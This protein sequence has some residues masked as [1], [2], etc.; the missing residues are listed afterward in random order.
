MVFSNTVD[1]TK[2]REETMFQSNFKRLLFQLCAFTGV[3][4]SAPTTSFGGVVTYAIADTDLGSGWRTSSGPKNDI[5]GNNILGSDGWFVSGAAGSTQ[6]P[7]YL[8]SLITNGSVYPGNG[9]YARIDDPNTTP[10]LTPSTLQS[11]TL[12]PFPGFNN[13]A[14]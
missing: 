14:T 1:V 6:L 4:L 8:V 3:V 11:G 5:D 10:G 7:A 2:L 12:N 9:S 13:T